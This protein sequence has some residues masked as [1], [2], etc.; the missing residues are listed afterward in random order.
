MPLASRV[1]NE[2]HGTNRVVYDY[3]LK[4]TGTIERE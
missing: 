4:P 1:I 2:V 3:T